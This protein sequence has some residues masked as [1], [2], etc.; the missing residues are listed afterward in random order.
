M[1]MRENGV[2]ERST[3]K[4]TEALG[5]WKITAVYICCCN[6]NALKVAITIF[7]IYLSF[8]ISLSLSVIIAAHTDFL[9]ELP[10]RLMK[11]RWVE[12]FL[13]SAVQIR[14]YSCMD[15]NPR[16]DLSLSL[17]LTFYSQLVSCQTIFFVHISLS[18]QLL[19]HVLLYYFM[20]APSAHSDVLVG[21]HFILHYC[22][23]P[24]SSLELVR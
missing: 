8:C 13:N 15:N 20:C 21:I 6:V 5:I 24:L 1:T 17:C 14:G 22:E 10:C 9:P 7:F 16:P 12:S 18:L 4:D 11:F 2:E 19:L 3:S 23:F